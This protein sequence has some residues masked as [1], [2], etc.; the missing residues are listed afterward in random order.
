MPGTKI[1]VNAGA[2]D[3]DPS[4][5]LFVSADIKQ[6]I[7]E[8]PYDPKRS[9]YVPHPEEKFAEGIV[10]ETDNNKV[11]VKITMGADAG[12]VKEFKQ[13]FVTQVLITCSL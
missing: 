1:V 8:K 9:V 3:P 11:K 2:E 7:M 13:E 12:E 4:P 5:Y 10:E 6:K